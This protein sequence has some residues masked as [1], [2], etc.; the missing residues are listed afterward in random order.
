M[1][2]IILFFVVFCEA[3]FHPP[4][5]AEESGKVTVP[6]KVVIETIQ[7]IDFGI[8]EA[9]RLGRI[10][11][12]DTTKERM[13]VYETRSIKL[14]KKTDKIPAAIGKKFGF[15]YIVKGTPEGA[16][17]MVTVNLLTPGLRRQGVGSNS[18]RE[19]WT[20]PKPIGKITYD[21]F[22]FENDWEL[23]P[24]KWTFQIFYD[25]RMLG[26]RSFEIYRQEETLPSRIAGPVRVEIEKLL[27]SDCEKRR[28][29]V[30]QLA[31][32]GKK[33]A[34]A[35]PYLIKNLK[36]YSMP[37]QIDF[38]CGSGKAVPP[39]LAKLG[40]PAIG[41]LLDALADEAWN[42]RA[43]A[44]E[45]LFR[46]GKPAVRPLTRALRK[47]TDLDVRLGAA[48]VLG[49][50]KDK[51]AVGPL[52]DSLQK[53]PIPEVRGKA[54]EVLGE[55][56]DKRAIKPL[57]EVFNKKDENW[58]VRSDAL[59]ALAK[60]GDKKTISR[61]LPVL[62]EEK[63][64]LV[65]EDV[66]KILG[67]M[68]DKGSTEYLLEGLKDSDPAIR[69]SS[70]EALKGKKDERALDPLVL[71]LKDPAWDVRKSAAIALGATGD[72]KAVEPLIRS[73][74]DGE[75]EVRHAAAFALGNL[76]AP[77]AVEP[78]IEMLQDGEGDVRCAAIRALGKIGD[79]RA[80]KPVVEKLKDRS[81]YVIEEAIKSLG[82]IKDPEA[83]G[84]LIAIMKDEKLNEK[85]A[86]QYHAVLSL[87]NIGE[88]AVELLIASL[89]NERSHGNRLRAIDALAKI[90]RP[91]VESLIQ[92]L[93][94]GDRYVREGAAEALGRIKD[95]RAVIP[96]LETLN[97]HGINHE[98]VRSLGMIGEP[99]VK[100]LLDMTGVKDPQVRM[101]VIEALGETKDRRA[102]DPL[103]K[104]LRD[105]DPRVRANAAKGLGKIM[106]RQVVQPLIE[107]LGDRNAYAR[108]CAAEALGMIK[109]KRAVKPL[110]ELLDSDP[111]S[112]WHAIEAL[113]RLGDKQ[114]V[115]KI[116][117]FLRDKNQQL[118]LKASEALGEIGDPCAVD[119]LI[120]TLN[121]E[122]RQVGWMA[123]NALKRITKKEFGRDPDEWR[124]WLKR[125]KRTGGHL[126]QIG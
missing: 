102:L 6:S 79:K 42:V 98:S 107:I 114:A 93:R 118:R 10:N 69:Q 116:C 7:I 46:M 110:M 13:G 67:V 36:Y 58:H 117:F 35:I 32:M 105:P 39:L 44:S 22:L 1:G 90:G 84:P 70:L 108:N 122:D 109:D 27:S 38:D 106:D 31:D 37:Y 57:I 94:D 30:H 85:L 12:E 5:W 43:G 120:D 47:N 4:V 17:A 2:A 18:Y 81:T 97:D 23:V 41:P 112:R 88:P 65:R 49:R 64:P 103:M 100:P 62:Y 119:A 71:A 80:L 104:A 74:K 63:D 95:S 76:R 72:P 25:G 26:E 126:S 101:Y 82:E 77:E 61:L 89:R 78:L 73:L 45:A 60:M 29:A 113:G 54:A 124:D 3:I 8:Y 21:G 19:S 96:L 59:K 66:V 52:I 75:R 121:D 48:E 34:P 91:A 87:V 20:V 24:G 115:N 28:S 53:D 92:S 50:I 55:I 14:I 99:S 125:H 16:Q 56:K 9:Q 123:W 68:G 83:I 33:A 111:D 51:R 40:K 86:A 15:R 11:A